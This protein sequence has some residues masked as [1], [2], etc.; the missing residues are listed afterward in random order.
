[1]SDAKSSAT[2]DVSS[3]EPSSTM[4]TSI[5]RYVCARTLATASRSIDARLKTGM[6]VVTSPPTPYIMYIRCSEAMGAGAGGGIA[7]ARQL[8]CESGDRSAPILGA[9]LR[10]RDDLL[11]RR[12]ANGGAACATR[13]RQSRHAAASDERGDFARHGQDSIRNRCVSIA[14]L[15]ARASADD[16]S[17]GVA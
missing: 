6:I 1:M 13:R 12:A 3:V 8:D 2:R 14:R 16:W 10:P 11:L 9:L 5:G 17:D 7:A 4:I 15:H